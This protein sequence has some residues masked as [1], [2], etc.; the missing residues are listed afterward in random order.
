M[1]KKFRKKKINCILNIHLIFLSFIEYFSKT[2]TNLFLTD[3]RIYINLLWHKD[4]I[5]ETSLSREIN[6]PF[7]FNIFS[8][9]ARLNICFQNLCRAYYSCIIYKLYSG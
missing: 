9:R 4:S 6:F 5:S 2:A 7:Q 8:N 1:I 3:E